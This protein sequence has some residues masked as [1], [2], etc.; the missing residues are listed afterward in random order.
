[1]S[2]LPGDKI[3]S[4]HW[5]RWLDVYMSSCLRIWIFIYLHISTRFVRTLDFDLENLLAEGSSHRN[6]RAMHAPTPLIRDP[7]PSSVR[8]VAGHWPW[9]VKVE[10]TYLSCRKIGPWPVQL[11][12]RKTILDG[13]L[14]VSRVHLYSP[15]L[16]HNCL[17]RLIRSH[18]MVTKVFHVE[19]YSLSHL[20]Y[21]RTV[22]NYKI[23]HTHIDSVWT[24][25]NDGYME[26]E[27]MKPIHTE[28]LRGYTVNLMPTKHRCTK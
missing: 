18:S 2:R 10:C 4:N 13:C 14:W 20:H 9:T 11:S 12:E 7:G 3:I 5:S 25:I 8:S 16:K 1:M 21:L 17:Y 22:S 26:N 23:S 27:A 19:H 28:Q 24:M 6:R 15:C